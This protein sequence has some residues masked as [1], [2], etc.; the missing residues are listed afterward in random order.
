MAS[1][2]SPEVRLDALEEHI[3]HQDH[4]ID[5]LNQ[6]A[7]KQWSEITN[8][9]ERLVV[10]SDKLQEMEGRTSNDPIGSPLPPHY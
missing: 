3:A 2:N 7:T 8:L 10:L 1:S 5:E 9:R 4:V 6:I